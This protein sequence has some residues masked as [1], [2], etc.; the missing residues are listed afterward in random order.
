MTEFQVIVS[1]DE[2]GDLVPK[3]EF[4]IELFGQKHN[5]TA[6]GTYSVSLQNNLIFN[7]FKGP[8]LI[9]ASENARVSVGHYPCTFKWEGLLGEASVVDISYSGIGLISSSQLERTSHISMVISTPEGEI[10]AEGTVK[11]CKRAKTNNQEFRIGVALNFEDR[12]SKA[13]WNALFV[14]L[15][16]A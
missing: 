7:V 3:Q 11:H 2:C 4:Q 9:P 14:K 10:K 8:D 6:R 5:L 13:R 16:A 15:L 12:I 1:I